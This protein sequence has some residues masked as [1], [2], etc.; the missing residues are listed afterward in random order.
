MNKNLIFAFALMFVAT[1]SNAQTVP[2]G[3]FQN[4]TNSS[5]YWTPDN[6]ATTNSLTSSASVYTAVKGGTSS[7]YYIKLTS[8]NIPGIGVVPGIAASGNLNTTTM[9]AT[10]GFP[11]AFRPTNFTGK[12]QYMGNSSNDVGSIRVYLTKWNSAMGMRDT[13]GYLIKNLTGMVMSWATFSLPITYNNSNTPDSCIIILN[14][15]GANPEAGSYLYADNLDFTGITSGVNEIEKL[16]SIKIVPNPAV[17]SIN[18]ELSELKLDANNIS[19][20]DLNGK[21]LITQDLKNQAKQNLDISVIPSGIYF[22]TINT[23]N[24]NIT[25][26]FI[27]Q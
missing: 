22:I 26:K 25:Q 11:F 1:I 19:I 5:G 18:I 12:W 8:Q 2:N 27:K 10:S 7:D 4:W 6:W 16:G 9:K 24:G 13:V 21:V 14:A 17:N 23:Q 3:T 20:L 15:S